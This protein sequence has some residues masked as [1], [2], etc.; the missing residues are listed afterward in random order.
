MANPRSGTPGR[1]YH[2]VS[3]LNEQAKSDFTARLGGAGIQF[4]HYLDKTGKN[5]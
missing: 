5:L 3:P 1:F 2:H 4:Q